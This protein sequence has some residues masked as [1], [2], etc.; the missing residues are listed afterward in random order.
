MDRWADDSSTATGRVPN[1][2]SQRAGGTGLGSFIKSQGDPARPAE[3]QP[4]LG[5][6]PSILIQASKR[7]QLQ[8]NAAKEIAQRLTAPPPAAGSSK[9]PSWA[10]EPPP[11]YYLEVIK[12]GATVQVRHLELCV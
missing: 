9:I 6:A 12:G 5:G 7:Q 3:V 4:E 8:A 11:G 2:S 10:K 1:F